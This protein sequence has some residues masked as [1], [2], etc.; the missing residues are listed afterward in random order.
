MTI[1]SY[2]DNLSLASAHKMTP[3]SAAIN[4]HYVLLLLTLARG[5]AAT[6]VMPLEL[7]LALIT[8]DA[9]CR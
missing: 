6:H 3:I 9:L 2:G 1:H 8:D 5:G 7:L 4:Y